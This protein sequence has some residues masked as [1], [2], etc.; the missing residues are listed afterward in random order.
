M[1]GLTKPGASIEAI[2]LSAAPSGRLRLED[3]MEIAKADAQG[4]FSNAKLT[5]DQTIREG[6]LVRMRSR[7]ADGTTSDWVTVKAKGVGPKDTRNAEVALF[8]I[9]MTDKGGGVVDVSN[10]NASR[11]VSEPGATLQFT[12]SR[13]N[14][15]SVV[16]I[17][18]KGGFPPGFTLKGKA[19]DSFAIAASDGV[20]NAS[21]AT[22]VGNVTVPGAT[23]TA[24]DLVPDPALHKTREPNA[25]GT[26]KFG[27]VRFTG[28]ALRRWHQGRRRAAGPA[29]RLLL[30][31]GVGGGRQGEPGDDS[32][33][34]QRQRR[35]HLHRDL[36]GARL[37]H[38][39]VQRR[40]HQGR[41]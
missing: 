27:K 32:E 17:T 33:A 26:P 25:D 41:R 14:E 20:N 30:P 12:N 36:Q 3:T 1:A 9:G 40:A 39:P 37:G 16:T 24:G 35:R 7:F 21:F 11:Q 34:H 29:G 4:A 13:T 38:Q 19:G 5:G 15:K 31:R 23:P 18:D 10:I 22:K 28:A 2:N 8:R 6:D